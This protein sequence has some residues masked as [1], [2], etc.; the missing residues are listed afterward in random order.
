MTKKFNCK[1]KKKKKKNQKSKK[2]FDK[3]KKTWVKTKLRKKQI[4]TKVKNLI[5]N[6]TQKSNC[7]IIKLNQTVI[8]PK[9]QIEKKLKNHYYDK[10][11]KLKL[12][13]HSKLNR[14]KNPKLKLWQNFKKILWQNKASICT[15][16]TGISRRRKLLSC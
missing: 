2:K 1:E 9:T 7:D 15:N 13:Q 14:E 4:V 8:K 10:I 16:L 12:W 5:C 11:W 3:T 6:K